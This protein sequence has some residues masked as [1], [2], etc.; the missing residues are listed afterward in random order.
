MVLRIEIGRSSGTGSSTGIVSEGVG[1]RAGV[2]TGG[3][4]GSVVSMGWV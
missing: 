2:V 4:K 1:I 3:G